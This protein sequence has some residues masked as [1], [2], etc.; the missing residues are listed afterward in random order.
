[1]FKKVR[2]V[3]TLVKWF[4]FGKPQWVCHNQI[5]LPCFQ[6]GISVS[7]AESI[8]SGHYEKREISIVGRHLESDDIVLELGAGIG[9]MASFCSKKIGAERVYTVEANPELIPII[10]ETFRR[11]EVEPQLENL[12]LGRGDGEETFIISHDVWASSVVKVT[13]PVKL[14]QIKKCD[15]NKRLKETAA[16]FL[17][18]DI[19][20]GELELFEHADLSRVRKICLETHEDIIGSVR[21][22]KVFSDLLNQGF[23]IDF[24]MIYRNVYY[25]YRP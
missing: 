23:V 17:I 19:E 15:L 4:V 8:Y 9:Y 2:R 21:T 18:I 1:M 12:I 13:L 5:W 7:V 25:F 16:T 11:N 10:N 24:Q 3:V 6:K 20:G 22:T 14:V